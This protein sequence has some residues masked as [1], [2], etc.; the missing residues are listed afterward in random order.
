MPVVGSQQIYFSG[1][2]DPAAI[3]QSATP[4]KFSP[5]YLCF[6]C[7]LLFKFFFPSLLDEPTKG[8]DIGAKGEIH[9]IIRRLAEENREVLV[10][11]V[12]SEE[13][14]ILA[15]ADDVIIFR[16]GRCDGTVYDPEALR[17]RDGSL[18]SLAWHQEEVEKP[19][20]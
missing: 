18:R 7:F 14:E 15:I 8:V 2:P 13:E 19:G 12:S 16:S 17:L 1:Q 10:L 9:R 5:Q 6:L 3:I 20:M 11:V 4:R